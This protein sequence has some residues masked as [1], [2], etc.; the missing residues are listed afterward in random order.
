MKKLLNNLQIMRLMDCMPHRLNLVKYKEKKKKK[1]V[2]CITSEKGIFK[3]Y[4]FEGMCES[5]TF[6]TEESWQKVHLNMN[7]MYQEIGGGIYA[8]VYQVFKCWLIISYKELAGWNIA[9][10]YTNQLSRHIQCK[11]LDFP[12]WRVMKVQRTQKPNHYCT[13]VKVCMRC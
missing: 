7:K 9:S 8:C 1:Q 5:G 3:V 2:I 13:T 4:I 6:S 12:L 11:L 10:K